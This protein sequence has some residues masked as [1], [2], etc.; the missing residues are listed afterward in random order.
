MRFRSSETGPASD[1]LNK[2]V[3]HM[4]GKRADDVPDLPRAILPKEVK[5]GGSGDIN[6]AHTI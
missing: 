5:F 6:I 3:K 4:I 2:P 1:E